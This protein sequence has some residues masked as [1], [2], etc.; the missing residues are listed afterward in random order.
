MKAN[1]NFGTNNH[2][3]LSGYLGR[4]VF[5]FGNQFGINW[6]MLLARFVGTIYF[7]TNFF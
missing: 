3:Y 4:D 6:E 7:R 1:Y 5:N 2:V